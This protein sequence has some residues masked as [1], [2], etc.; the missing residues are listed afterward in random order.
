MEKAA[1]F[2]AGI[3]F[4]RLQ[5]PQVLAYLANQELVQATDEFHHTNAPLSYESVVLL[6]RLF[7][8]K[9]VFVPERTG[10]LTREDL[11]IFDEDVLMND[12]QLAKHKIS[13]VLLALPEG[14]EDEEDG[15]MQFA[16]V[17]ANS[18]F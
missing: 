6:S 7:C 18:S 5:Y 12:E 16:I 17:D 8:V 2:L 14:A 10:G 11:A 13:A 9:G 1:A 4:G 15:F 3:Q